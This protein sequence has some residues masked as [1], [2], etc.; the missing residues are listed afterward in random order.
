MIPIGPYF[1][2]LDITMAPGEGED[3]PA[4]QDV[5]PTRLDG[6]VGQA[7][8]QQRHPGPRLPFTS[9]VSTPWWMP[10]WCEMVPRNC[11]TFIHA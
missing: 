10:P 1:L 11:A 8:L 5:V 9:A 3:D 4:D 2:S 6:G 7:Q